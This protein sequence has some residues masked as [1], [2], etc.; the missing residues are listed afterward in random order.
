M[1]LLLLKQRTA[2]ATNLLRGPAPT[3][4][5]I[6]AQVGFSST[7]ALS[8]AVNNVRGT[9]PSKYRTAEAQIGD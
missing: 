1:H 8:V 4:G 7:C 3:I 5:A 9:S 2:P 6:A